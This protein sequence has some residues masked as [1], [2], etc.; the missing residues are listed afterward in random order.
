MIQTLIDRF[1]RPGNSFSLLLLLRCLAF[2]LLLG[3]AFLGQRIYPELISFIHWPLLSL[4][5]VLAALLSLINLV[6]NK[7]F[8]ETPHTFFTLVADPL[9]WFMAI[10]ATG[11]AINPAISYVLVLLCIAAFTLPLLLAC[12]ILLL[13]GTAYAALMLYA[14]HYHHAMMMSWHLWGMWILFIA[15]ALI[16]LWVIVRLGAL[17]R[18][19]DAAIARFR[20]ETVRDEQLIATGTLAAAVT[21]EIGTP[22]S[23]IALL[24]EDK[25]DEDSLLIQQQV[26]R[27]KEAITTLRNARNS[28]NTALTVQ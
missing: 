14:P 16:M 23:S 4:A 15:N 27:C 28:E 10:A 7:R 8:N 26:Q 11:A 24:V 25:E 6:G 22:L 5:V 17:I 13:M 2:A 3:C 1:K 12:I 19:K 20:E 9:L 21:H 18:E